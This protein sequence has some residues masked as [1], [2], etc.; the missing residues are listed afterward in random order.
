MRGLVT[1]RTVLDD[2]VEI[3]VWVP[4]VRWEVNRPVDD[5]VQNEA[6]SSFWREIEA[7]D[8]DVTVEL[9]RVTADERS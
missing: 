6:I 9:R 8:P 7:L 3:T 2:A 1:H 5:A 4:R